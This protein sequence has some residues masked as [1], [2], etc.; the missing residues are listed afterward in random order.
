LKRLSAFF[1]NLTG[2]G[3]SL[4]ARDPEAEKLKEFDDI[5]KHEFLD[6]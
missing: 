1:T 4:L 6:E 3:K 2:K 5:L